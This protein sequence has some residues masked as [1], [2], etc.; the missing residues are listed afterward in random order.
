MK[1]KA[2]K[3]RKKT[4]RK[5]TVPPVT[6]G[7]MAERIKTFDWGKTPLGR[8]Q[9][10][11]QSLKNIISVMLVNRFPMLLWWGEKYVQFYNDAYIPIPGAKH[12][13]ALGQTGEV[14]WSEIWPVLK[15]L[16]DTPFSG[17]PST[18]M[19]D[20]LLKINRNNF[21]EET[22]F[23]IAYSPVPDPKAPRK[24]GGVLATVI[25]I[26]G[27]IIGKRQMETLG[28]L[29]KAV[30]TTLSLD[31]VLSQVA[32][33]FRGNPFDIPFAFIHKISDDGTR[34]E[35][36]TTVGYQNGDDGLPDKVIDLR[37]PGEKWD[38]FLQSVRSSEILTVNKQEHWKDLPMGAWDVPADCLVHVPIREGTSIPVAVITIG[39]NPYRKFD[40]TYLNFIQLVADQA[41]LGVSKAR[42]F[43]QEHKRAKLLEELDRAKT[44][45][46]SNIS[47][48][49]R[50]PLTLML[51]TLELAMREPGVAP[52]NVDRLAVAHRNALRLLKL[53]NTLLDFSRIESGR[54]KARYVKTDVASLTTSLASNFDS[55]IANADITFTVSADKSMPEV[56]VDTPMWEKIVFNLLSNAFK[57]THKGT[58][59]LR[60]FARDGRAVLEVEDTGIG[61]PEKEL[62]RMFE[63]FHRVENAQGRT[64][65]G[66][67][68]G[69]SLTKELVKLLGG[70]ISVSSREGKGSTFTVSLPLGKDHLPASEVADFP[71]IIEKF[72]EAIH[73]TYVNDAL[74]VLESAA[75]DT[76]KGDP[77]NVTAA[78]VLIVDD[79]SDMRKHIR[80]L[81]ETQFNVLTASNGHKAL[82]LIRT[83][84]PDLVLSDVMMPVMD[85]IQLL[86]AVKGN[87]ATSNLPII[88]LTARAGEES[89]IEGLETGA[90][91]YLVKP[92]SANELMSRIRTQLSITRRRD[93]RE[94]ELEER[95]KERTTE[96]RIKNEEL[97][98]TNK[99]LESFNYV[100]SHDLQEPLRK[101]QTFTH[102]IEQQ[103][104]SE[105]NVKKYL[106][107]IAVS[108]RRM[109]ELINSIL[110]YSRL[111]QTAGNTEPT[112]LNRILENVKTDFELIIADKRA[113]VE[114]DELPVV[115]AMPLG[116]HQLFSNLISNSLKF[117]EKEPLIRISSTVVDASDVEPDKPLLPQ[118]KYH[119]LTF[120]DNGIGFRKEY[121]EQIFKLFQRLN[122]RSKYAGTGV[123]LS[124]VAKIVSRHNGF[125]AADS[126]PGQGATFKVWLPV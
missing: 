92:F 53:V 104:A 113:M 5:N 78:R 74:S 80:A 66:T 26:T 106:G 52:A 69:L 2:K 75:E 42:E 61:I 13:S 122:N 55:I 91:D 41:I 34:A 49:F 48:E 67:G 79:N 11:S 12:P 19:D 117:C 105:E 93:E 100:A 31:D 22:H 76:S 118:G 37:A 120:S 124:I 68:I 90:D 101:I 35:L 47:H 33:V 32:N 83:E 18:W 116:M 30:S 29:G 119:Q 17:G 125:I 58:I 110:V 108:A 4:Y 71:D 8:P 7:E 16:V 64:Y 59:A 38:T 70:E 57:Y 14:C 99:E 95:V 51:G 88:L 6:G 102:L 73:E 85:G 60:L 27:E 123:G 23:T 107:K 28:R 86:K 15:P 72:D 103:A 111:P 40:D 24:I 112:D 54:Q 98:L 94:R 87:P 126:T 82:E 10:W 115:N 20:I 56:Y 36:F 62:P 65:E 43:E 109:S 63:R 114:S 50:T 45:F 81:L 1:T 121:R 39:L 84:P 25:E 9:R 46:F 44:I 96:L 89:K 77:K 3:A 97:E 21:I